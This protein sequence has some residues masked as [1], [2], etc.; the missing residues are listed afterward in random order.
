MNSTATAHSKRPVSP[1]LAALLSFLWPGLGQ[2]YARRRLSA[3]LFATPAL[4]LAAIG[5]YAA[6][7]GLT[8]LFARLLDPSAAAAV[9]VAVVILGVWRLFAVLHAFG[10][11]ERRLRARFVER[12]ALSV[13]LAAIVASHAAG[14]WLVASAYQMDLGIFRIGGGGAEAPQGTPSS[15]RL[16]VL[17]AGVD[18]YPTRSETLYDS[19]MVVSVDTDTKRISLVSVP[20]DTTGYPLY[21]GG[22][23]TIKINAIPTYVKNGWLKSPDQP[24]TTLI[25]EVSYLV[26]V[27]I[28]YYGVLDLASF[29]KI[30]D[31]VGGV[32]IVNPSTIVDPTYDWLNGGPLGFQLSAGPHHMDGRNALAYARSRHGSGNSDWARAG[33]QQQLLVAV[34]HKMASPSMFVRLPDLMSQAASLVST[35]F[36]ASRVADVVD[37]AQSVPS[38][39]YDE[40]VLGPPYSISTSTASAST[41]CLQLDKVAPLSVKLFGTDSRYYGKTQPPTC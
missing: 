13:L 24:V 11:G 17:L 26:G 34:A 4:A 32:D 28:D 20:R 39:N 23:G 14:A 29:M 5:L 30:I 1:A 40:Y 35:N 18:A 19:L 7:S 41:T 2:M 22:K 10:S 15:A 36:P 9:F 31:M 33:R 37:F 25:K 8:V 3:L 27:P 16:T 21:W 6:R 12:L 38:A